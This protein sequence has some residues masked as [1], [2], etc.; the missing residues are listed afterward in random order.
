MSFC[1]ENNLLILNYQ[2]SS[3]EAGET[4]LIIELIAVIY[5]VNF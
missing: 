5:I 2:L 1:E 4:N 3:E